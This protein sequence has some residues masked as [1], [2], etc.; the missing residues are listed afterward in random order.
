MTDDDGSGQPEK[1]AANRDDELEAERQARQRNRSI[2]IAVSLALLV[3][4][5]YIVTLVKMSDVMSGKPGS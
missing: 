3:L 4:L 2:A 1:G 5:F